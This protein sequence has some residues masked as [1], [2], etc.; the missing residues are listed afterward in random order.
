[1]A[2]N[3]NKL[4]EWPFKDIIQTYTARDTMFYSLTLGI[5]SDPMD[6]DQ[7]KFVY[8]KN[9]QAFPT[10][11]VVLGHPGAWIANPESGI[12]ISKL[13]FGEEILT[14]HQ[15]LPPEATIRAREKVT[16]VVDKG[17]G[18]GALLYCQ[19]DIYDHISGE[20][21]ATIEHTFFCRADGGFGGETGPTTEPVLIPDT[22]PDIVLDLDILPQAALLYRLNADLNP[23]HS[24]PAVA[25]AA[26]FSKPILHG[27][28]TY[29]VA[30][31]AVVKACCGYDAKRLKQFRSRFTAP[32]FPGETISFELWQKGPEISFRAWVK[33]RNAKVLDNGRAIIEP[34]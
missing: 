11:A 13:V 34:I 17:A 18:R 30:A 23:L 6:E 14:L 26:G 10:M 9:L 25:K 1:M 24:D 2:I 33:E 5:G 8:E 22:S 28:C 19:R 4:L 29:G 7:L 12:D 20:Q 31:H 15:L 21:L 27:L 32:V 3:V 16:H